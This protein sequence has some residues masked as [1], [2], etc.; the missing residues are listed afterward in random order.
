M[1]THKGAGGRR[2]QKYKNTTAF[3][4]ERYGKSR[5]VMLAG[6]LPLAGLCARCKEKLEWKKKYGKYKPLTVPK[7]CVSCEEKKV[8]QAYYRLCQDCAQTNQVCAKC[9]EKEEVLER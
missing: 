5:Q 2:G 4:V 8:K 6:A 3:N 7:K 1:S 9:G